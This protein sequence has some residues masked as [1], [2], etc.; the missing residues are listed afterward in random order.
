MQTAT[1]LDYTALKGD[2]KAVQINPHRFDLVRAREMMLT[3]SGQGAVDA[4][5]IRWDD[6]NWAT[7]M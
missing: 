6:G 1:A 2:H 4:D 3:F 7:V 5:A